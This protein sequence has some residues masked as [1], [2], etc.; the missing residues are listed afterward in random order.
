MYIVFCDFCEG[1]FFDKLIDNGYVHTSK[2][3]NKLVHPLI[4]ISLIPVYYENNIE[5]RRKIGT[6]RCQINESTH[7]WSDT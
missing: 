7:G 3:S 6:F 4:N 5:F 2:L 1:D